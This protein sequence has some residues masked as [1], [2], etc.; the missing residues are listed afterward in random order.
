[1]NFI[2][3]SRNARIDMFQIISLL[4]NA[5]CIKKKLYDPYALAYS[6]YQRNLICGWYLEVKF[7]AVFPVVEVAVKQ[8]I[9]FYFSQKFQYRLQF[10]KYAKNLP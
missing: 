6:S 9:S 8:T 1:M 7:K 4:R 3:L 2:H 10:N 5:V